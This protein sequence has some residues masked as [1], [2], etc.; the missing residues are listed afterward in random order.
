M[1]NIAEKNFNHTGLI[2]ETV[3]NIN[4]DTTK[5][6]ITTPGGNG[7]FAYV[8]RLTNPNNPIIEYIEFDDILA[9]PSTYLLTNA[10]TFIGL[11]QS[12]G[13]PIT[14][15]NVVQQ[16]EDFSRV[17]LE[18]IVRIGRISHFGNVE[19]TGTFNLSLMIEGDL[20]IMAK[21]IIYGTEKILDAQISANGANLK[22]D[23]AYGC[24][25]RVG[26]GSTRATKNIPC[27]PISPQMPFIPAYNDTDGTAILSASVTD[28]DCTQYDNGAG[29]LVGV[30]SNNYANIYIY[31]FPYL[32]TQ[33]VFHIYGKTNANTLDAAIEVLQIPADFH[34]PT[35]ILG[36]ILLA[37]ITMREDQINLTTAIAGGL[38][39][40]ILTDSFGNL[41]K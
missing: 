18:T 32:S 8:D 3:I 11:D 40:I 26:A 27:S 2:Y 22:I 9:I 31:F 29:A 19:I 24:F 7:K 28:I 5:F 33:T 17:Q 16:V 6:D 23:R 12:L 39:K 37:S 41:I 21:A 38:A 35:D 36:G 20:D 34:I 13:L 14:S 1:S 15:A 25:Y 4:A 30:G 10:G